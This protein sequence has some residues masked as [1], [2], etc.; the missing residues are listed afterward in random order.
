M[1][2]TYDPATGKP[3]CATPGTHFGGD[4]RAEWHPDEVPGSKQG[5]GS[6]GP[7]SGDRGIGQ[8]SADT[9]VGSRFDRDRWAAASSAPGDGQSA[10]DNQGGSWLDRS[11]PPS[12]SRFG[13]TPFTGQAWLGNVPAKPALPTGESALAG[14]RIVSDAS[15]TD[16]AAA[17]LPNTG[18]TEQ[19]TASGQGTP[20]PANPDERN[21]GEHT[22]N[23]S[24]APS[25]TAKPASPSGE[26]V[27]AAENIPTDGGARVDHEAVPPGTKGTPG[28]AAAQALNTTNQ[29]VAV[30]LP[31]GQNIADPKSPTGKLM[32]PVADLSV[33]AAE[34][35]RIG[36]AYR[37]M[38]NDPMGTES[39]PGLLAGS[40]GVNVGQGGSFDYQRQGNSIAGFTQL[41]QFRNVANV[42]VGLLSQ[43]AGL[44]LEETLT[45]AGRFASLRSRNANPSGP[46]GLDPE[47]AQFII[48]GFNLS[49]TGVS[50]KATPP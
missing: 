21:L 23:G 35:R 18:S 43:Q 19:L 13:A 5:G 41:P 15:T 26:P 22:S 2:A 4:I 31:N 1:R 24:A 34:G 3:T 38:L 47:T 17:T 49:K 14:S 27:R 16:G 25:G 32:S 29:G 7:D 6:P 44:T 37:S 39:A 9:S 33:V 12:T 10:P 40:L 45:F 42:N 46:Y 11:R 50:G 30:Q 28:P 8:S 36:A 48:T 20:T